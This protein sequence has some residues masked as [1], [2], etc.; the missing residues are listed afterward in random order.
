MKIK[1]I[2]SFITAIMMAV[3]CF[4]GTLVSAEAM[5]RVELGRDITIDADVFVL[6]NKITVSGKSQSPAR[7][8]LTYLVKADGDIISVGQMRSNQKGV[9]DKTIVLDDALYDPELTPDGE[10]LISGVNINTLKQSIRLFSGAQLNEAMSDLT[11]VET[12]EELEQFLINNNEMLGLGELTNDKA[13]EYIKAQYELFEKEKPETIADLDELTAWL[14]DY[15][16]KATNIFEFLDEINT[17]SQ[18]ERW[19]EI[20]KLVTET[21]VDLLE[22]DV[23]KAESVDNKGMFLRMCDKSYTLLKDVEEAYDD[24]YTA[25]TKAESQDND[26]KGSGGSR[27]GS[28]GGS[29]SVYDKKPQGTENEKETVDE[30]KLP[31]KAFT[32]IE[33]FEWAKEAIEELRVRGI[34]HGNGNGAFEP[35]R[36]ITR[37]EVLSILMGLF[38]TPEP[39]KT[40][41]FTDINKDDWCYDVVAKA[42]GLGIVTGMPDGS[43]GKGQPVTRADLAVM[44]V[45][46]T[47][48]CNIELTPVKPIAVF[49]D[50][51]NIPGYAEEMISTLQ[52]TGIVNG[53]DNGNYKPLDGAT[54]A[55]SAVLIYNL[56]N[57]VEGGR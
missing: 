55:E 12:Q 5:Q 40:G 28:S 49:K 54:R 17:A 30:V 16:Q 51:Y 29:F 44:I 46:L 2:V 34:V 20:E 19:G 47:K 56:I 6:G 27:G 53:D 18:N 41:Q 14:A 38:K 42:S 31:S 22:I 48:I 35:D 1:R 33:G 3:G 39:D 8:N 52:Q 45:R 23:S 10:I 50:F 25:Q 21:Y 13:T 11:S 15:T 26:E 43:F 37:E 24:A 4:G 36:E 9:F 7:L 32:D 57:A